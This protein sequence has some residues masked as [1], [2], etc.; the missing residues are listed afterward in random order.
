MPR[1][2][3]AIPILAISLVGVVVPSVSAGGTAVPLPSVM[4]A[5]G[6][7]I[8]QAA[9][10]GGSL[11]ADYPQN[12][13][14]TGTNTSVNS[15]YLRLL[16]AG[17][18]IN[19]Q[20]HNLSVSGSKV[21]D[22]N[23]Q[24]STVTALTPAADYLTVQIGGNDLCTDT[25]A[26]MTP[27]DTFRAQ[28]QLAMAT[29]TAGSP[30]TN[31][32]VVSIPDAYQLWSLFHNNFWARFV[33][34]VGGVCQS[35]LANPTST[36]TVDVQRR[37]AVRQRNIDYN[38]QLAEVCA[39]FSHCRWDGNAIFNVAFTSSDV[40]GDYFHPSIAGQAKLAAASW[41]V[42]YTWASTPPPPNVAP[43]AS[44]TSSCA[45]LTCTFTDTS[46]DSDGTIASRSWTFGDGGTSTATN[47]SHAFPTA[48]TYMVGL[49][50]T[51]NAGATGSTTVP[52]TVSEP[53]AAKPMWVGNLTS[54]TT[55][56]SRNWTAIVTVTVADASGP[57]G[58]AVVTGSWSAGSGGTACTTN[59]AGQCTVTSS[60]LSRKN[61]ASITYAVSGLAKT[62][63][64]YAPGS[65][66]KSSITVSRP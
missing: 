34:S 30:N 35:L 32:Y 49:T 45:G 25:F 37:A 27:V 40:A 5:V 9:S 57:V 26:A 39:A 36:Q 18:P 33:W 10:T 64:V 55:T 52:T 15:H 16:G 50:V 2:I 7:S 3:F 8:T 63:W 66:V 23:A 43:T 51:D 19:G 60:S 54:T 53:P 47:P 61:V 58:G 42:G 31:V 59:T 11:G 13:W 48:G 24:M 41:A 6:D 62:G 56:T 65:N 38:T 44:F 46:T 28:F 14:A 17:A 22:L 20:N 21:A 29:L 4:A 12:S 1:R